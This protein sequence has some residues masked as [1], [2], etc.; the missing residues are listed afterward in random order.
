M[1]EQQEQISY[2]WLSHLECTFLVPADAP[3][4]VSNHARTSR[5]ALQ[6]QHVV[7]YSTAA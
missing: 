7:C 1:Q 3:E 4:S 6:Q 5:R 2:A